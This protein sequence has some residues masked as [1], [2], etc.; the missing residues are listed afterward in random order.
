[1]AARD[2]TLMK[3]WKWQ[4]RCSFPHGPCSSLSFHSVYIPTQCCSICSSVKSLGN[5]WVQIHF[6]P[7]YSPR[8]KW[9]LPTEIFRRTCSRCF[10]ILWSCL[11][12]DDNYC[13]IDHSL[14]DR[15]WRSSLTF[16]IFHILPSIHKSF[17]ATKNTNSQHCFMME[18]FAYNVKRTWCYLLQMALNLIA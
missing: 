5:H 13:C 10:V 3:K 4:L 1:M 2:S 9:T 14:C 8:I 18:S 16:K 12:L 15:R 17:M 11:K 7:K 6:I